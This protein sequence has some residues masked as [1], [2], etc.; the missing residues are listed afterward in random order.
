MKFKTK[1]LTEYYDDKKRGNVAVC[2]MYFQDL[3]GEFDTPKNGILQVENCRQGKNPGAEIW[4]SF[5]YPSS[6][7]NAKGIEQI[8]KFFDKTHRYYTGKQ[9]YNGRVLLW[10]TLS[11]D[12]TNADVK[13]L[14]KVFSKEEIDYYGKDETYKD[15]TTKLLCLKKIDLTK[16]GTLTKENNPVPGW[17]YQGDR[18]PLVKQLAKVSGA[19]YDLY[20]V[21]YG[22]GYFHAYLSTDDVKGQKSSP[23]IV[24]MNACRT[25]QFDYDPTRSI[26]L[27]YIFDTDGTLAAMGPTVEANWSQLYNMV[28]RFMGEGD[29]LGRAWLRKDQI[30]TL[31]TTDVV[32][33]E[34]PGK[35]NFHDHTIPDHGSTLVGDPFVRLRD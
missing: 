3:D 11:V 21:H 30:T 2:P 22:G 32:P 33:T 6:S 35:T 4:V 9:K 7:D 27:A 18:N 26:A 10:Q 12:P 23:K 17:K 24:C 20:E 13:E 5:I 15:P 8:K 28:Y 25:G 34:K 16:I 1:L 29:Y 14:V 19:L 31:P